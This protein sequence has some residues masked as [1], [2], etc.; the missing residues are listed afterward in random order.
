VIWRSRNTPKPKIGL[1]LPGGGARAAYQVGVLKAVASLLPK[2]SPSPFQVITGTSAGSINAAALAIHADDFRLGVLRISRVWKNFEAEQVYR[3]D[4]WGVARTGL[5]WLAAMALGGLGRYNPHSLLDRS[6]LY[7]LLE[8]SLPCEKIQRAIDGGWLHALGVTASGYRS[9]HSVTFFQAHDS[10]E[11][12]ARER[13]LGRAAPI[14]VD[15]LM[16]SSAIPFLFSAVRIG[17]EYFGDGSV[18]QVAPLS[19]ALHLGSDRVLVVG[20]RRKK[21]ACAQDEEEAHY[22]TLAEVGGHILDSIFLDNLD[23]DLERLA[24]INRTVSLIPGRRLMQGGIALRPIEVLTITPSQSLDAIAARHA[25]LLP[26]ALRYLLRGV[27]AQR[28]HGAT[29]VS[30]LLFEKPYCRALISLGYHDAMRRRD[31]IL[32]LL[33]TERRD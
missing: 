21:A 29:L 3:T 20:I 28:G 11:P 25:H 19:G 9:G 6:P 33:D 32:K 17:N 15:H 18:R 16:A 13:R 23:T 31:D 24:R 12:W 10:V 22:P 7:P 14:T 1:V 4:P 5:H 27:G 8:R 2:G 30:Y 26:R